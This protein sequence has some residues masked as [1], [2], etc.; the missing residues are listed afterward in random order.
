MRALV[1]FEREYRLRF[2][3]CWVIYFFHHGVRPTGSEWFQGGGGADVP[4]MPARTGVWTC[5]RMRSRRALLPLKG[6]GPT[7][8]K[9][10]RGGGLFHPR[11]RDEVIPTPLFCFAE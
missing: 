1:L 4:K 9:R 11:P 10:S 6:G 8:A 2:W 7:F 5:V 3:A